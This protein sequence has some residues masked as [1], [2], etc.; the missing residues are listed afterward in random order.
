[1]V[2]IFLTFYFYQLNKSST[3]RRTHQYNFIRSKAEEEQSASRS[4]PHHVTSI[5]VEIRDQR[6][7]P[8]PFKIKNTLLPSVSG[9]GV[10]HV[11]A[12]DAEIHILN[13]FPSRRRND[14][15][16]SHKALVILHS[17]DLMTRMG[18]SGQS[19]VMVTLKRFDDRIV[20]LHIE[21]SVM[22]IL[23]LK[24]GDKIGLYWDERS[25]GLRYSKVL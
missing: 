13:Y 20:C 5:P 25:E 6:P 9:G 14:F 19:S 7:A 16:R 11:T 4:N 8:S 2:F 17:H 21:Q 10:L 22:D 23:G 3:M 15:Q 12:S 18:S 24:F 1:M